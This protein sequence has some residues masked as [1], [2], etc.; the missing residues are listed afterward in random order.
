MYSRVIILKLVGVILKNNCEYSGIAPEALN[1]FSDTSN[2][3]IAYVMFSIIFNT[4]IIPF[5]FIYS[6]LWAKNIRSR[7]FFKKTDTQNCPRPSF[8]NPPGPLKIKRI[9]IVNLN[10]DW[11]HSTTPSEKKTTSSSALFPI[12]EITT[13]DVLIPYILKCIFIHRFRRCAVKR[14]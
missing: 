4:K 2:Y 12:N 14:Q 5:L 11:R 9:V 10:A 3:S 1:I 13:Q 8:Q 6:L 7:H